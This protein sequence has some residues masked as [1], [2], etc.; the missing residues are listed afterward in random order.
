MAD[1]AGHFLSLCCRG[2]S[3][4]AWCVRRAGAWRPAARSPVGNHSLLPALRFDRADDEDSGE[5]GGEGGERGAAGTSASARG[6]RG[7]AAA[8]AGPAGGDSL[9]ALQAQ[10]AALLADM[11]EVKALLL[12][13]RRSGGLA[14]Q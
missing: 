11:A 7:S 8:P 10:V 6:G 4:A 2:R 5:G 1:V 12:A 3:A 13:Q 14:A 9:A